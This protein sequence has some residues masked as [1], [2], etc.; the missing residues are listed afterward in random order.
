MKLSLD[1][2]AYAKLIQGDTAVADALEKAEDIYIS[3]VVAGELFSG[4]ALGSKAKQNNDIL[5]DFLD[6]EAKIV[7]ITRSTAVW[8]AQ[9]FKHLKSHGT[10]IPTND[11][12]IASAAFETG[13]GLLTFDKHF[14][15]VPGLMVL[16][17]EF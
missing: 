17:P 2:N 8:Y 6:N 12:W 7:A 13:S 3:A 9:I 5:E 14:T 1:T 10:P 16:A 4:F 15:L 11:I